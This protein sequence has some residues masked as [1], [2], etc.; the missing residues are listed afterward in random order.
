MITRSNLKYL[1]IDAS[2]FTVSLVYK[3]SVYDKARGLKLE[4]KR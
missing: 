3:K 2:N 4:L 1:H